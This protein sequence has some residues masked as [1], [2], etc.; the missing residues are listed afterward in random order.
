MIDSAVVPDL[1]FNVTRIIPAGTM[2]S[3]PVAVP[4]THTLEHL[5]LGQQ[6]AWC[7]CNLGASPQHGGLARSH[8]VHLGRERCQEEHDVRNVLNLYCA[9]DVDLHRSGRP[10]QLARHRWR[11]FGAVAHRHHAAGAWRAAA[12][13][14]IT[15]PWL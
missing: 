10:S 5:T 7:S 14:F 9:F 6:V 3:D 12:V 1:P 11:A 13:S 15:G 4:L 8:G 2:A